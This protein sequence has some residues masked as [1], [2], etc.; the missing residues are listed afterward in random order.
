MY[1]MKQFRSIYV[2]KTRGLVFKTFVFFA[3]IALVSACKPNEIEGKKGK[4]PSIDEPLTT[5]QGFSVAAIDG[6]VVV[7]FTPQRAAKEYYVYFGEDQNMDGIT[8]VSITSPWLTKAN[9]ITVRGLSTSKTYYFAAQAVGHDDKESGITSAISVTPGTTAATFQE[10]EMEVKIDTCFHRRDE[11]RFHEG[12][13]KL[14]YHQEASEHLNAHN[15]CDDDHVKITIFEDL[16]Q[17]NTF[18]SQ[19][20]YTW[21]PGVSP[22][23]DLQ[24]PGYKTDG[25]N[26]IS[27]SVPQLISCPGSS[28]KY[29]HI[30]FLADQEQMPR[31]I[32]FNALQCGAKRVIERDDVL[33]KIRVEVNPSLYY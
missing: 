9:I 28:S 33:F 19:R 1:V 22:E 30:H 13:L 5:P 2:E 32:Q 16:D 10:V 6:G 14:S 26:I 8:G 7:S 18:E 12:K 4:G 24:I 25:L 23:L 11:I 27:Y 20:S 15:K 29:A 31:I 21:Q 17:N 3:L